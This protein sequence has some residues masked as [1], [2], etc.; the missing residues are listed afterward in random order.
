LPAELLDFWVRCELLDSPY[1]HPEDLPILR[2]DE[3]GNSTVMPGDFRSFVHSPLFG[4]FGDTRF[5]LSLIPQPFGG[6][7]HTA[8]IIIFLLNPGF[9]YQ[10]YYGEYQVPG[11]RERL[12]RVVKRNSDD[13]EFPFIWLDP[14]ICW[15]GGFIW[16]ERRLREV[17]AVIAKKEFGGRYLDALR[18]LSRRLAHVELVPYHS[19]SFKAHWLIEKLPSA[20]AA[21]AFAKRAAASAFKSEKTIIV[22]RQAAQ[23]GITESSSHVVLYEG[24]LTPGASLGV[25]TPGGK[26]ILARYGIEVS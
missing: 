3:A 22:P 24:G 21:K 5:H 15:H 18:S 16:W 14:E 12:I 10:D 11:F 25:N 7:L 1:V 9:S 19:P 20:Q 2:Q 17:I 23:W 6:R 26:A 8:D 13:A 4:Y